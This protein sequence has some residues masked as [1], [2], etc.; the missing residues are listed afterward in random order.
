MA[1]LCPQL[2]V[3]MQMQQLFRNPGYTGAKKEVQ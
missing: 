1:A 2:A 3:K